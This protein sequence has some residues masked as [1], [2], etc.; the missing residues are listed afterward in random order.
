MSKNNP[1]CDVHMYPKKPNVE[2]LFL[3]LQF[4]GTVCFHP[5]RRRW[6]N[7]VGNRNLGQII[8]P[9]NF[10]AS[11]E[12]EKHRIIVILAPKMVQ[13]FN[14]LK[15]QTKRVSNVGHFHLTP[16]VTIVFSIHALHLFG[17]SH[18]LI[19]KGELKQHITIKLH[20]E[21]VDCFNS[22]YRIIQRL[23]FVKSMLNLGHRF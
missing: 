1:R 15:A 13:E 7:F 6:D 19:N 9:I 11:T 10:I 18:W 4:L 22:H 12:L 2:F 20:G 5:R 16:N 8:I 3:W 14:I 17:N 23:Q 21:K